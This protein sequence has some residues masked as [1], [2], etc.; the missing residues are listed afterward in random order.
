MK[1]IKRTSLL[2]MRLSPLR[3][4]LKLFALWVLL[5]FHLLV[6]AISFGQSD[7]KNIRFEY[8][9]IEHGL[10]KSIV[11]DIIRDR[12][13]FMWFATGYGLNRFDGYN[14][15]VFKN[16]PFNDSS[17]PSNDIRT[18]YEDPNGEIWIGSYERGISIY[19][20]E[21]ENFRS[22]SYSETDN[23][24]LSHNR[25]NT[26]IGHNENV[27]IGTAHGLNRFDKKS[28]SFE[29]YFHEPDNP[30]S[31][32][33]NNIQSLLIDSQGI[34]WVGTRNGLNRY[35]PQTDD[36]ERFYADGR[37]GSLP[38]STILALHEDPKGNLW[39]GTKN[40]GLCKYLPHTNSFKIHPIGPKIDTKIKLP[41]VLSIESDDEGKL[42]I[43]TW[44]SGLIRLNPHT[45]I[46]D[47]FLPGASGGIGHDQ[48]WNVYN[49]QFG[50]MWFGTHGGGVNKYVPGSLKF[51][52]YHPHSDNTNSLNDKV[53]LSIIE[54]S[55]GYVWIGTYSGGLN[56][57]DQEG[58]FKAYQAH[59]DK[60]KG[61]INNRTSLITEDHKGNLWIGSASVDGVG[62]LNYFNR[63]SNTFTHYR[64]QPYNPN[65]LS[66]DDVWTVFLDPDSILW[67][68]TGGAGLDRYD[69]RTGSFSN[70]S[71]DPMD[72]TTISDNRIHSIY[73]DSY[74][75]M[76]VCTRSGLN[77][78]D[79]ENGKF[80]RYTLDQ[81]TPN[82]ISDNYVSNIL[83]DNSNRYW[84]GTQNGLNLFNYETGEFQNIYSHHG[85]PG[86][87]IKSI[88][89]DEQGFLWISTDRG[90]AR[91]NPDEM[92]FREYS[93]QDGLQSEE[94][95]ENAAFK[96]NSGM[97]YFG[98][99]NGFNMFH[100]DSI[101][102][103]PYIPPVVI[104]ELKLFNEPVQHGAEGSPLSKS[105]SYT[106]EIRLSYRQSMITFEFVALNFTNPEKNQYA[107]K[108][109]GFDKD[110]VYTGSQR[111]AV[112]TNLNPGEYIFRVK[113]SNN[114]KLWNEE[115]TSVRLVIAPPFWKTWWFRVLLLIVIVAGL[116]LLHAARVRKI[117]LRKKV[118][119]RQVAERTSEVKNQYKLLEE[120][121]ILLMEQREEL[122]LQTE[123]LLNSNTELE[124]HRSKIKDQAEKIARM[125]AFLEKKNL[126]L[127]DEVKN[128][129]QA[130][131]M[132]KRV[133]FEEFKRIY[134]DD[135]S[136]F[137][138]LDDL[139]WS[140]GFECRKCG[141]TEFSYTNLIKYS[142][143]F[144]RRCK[145]CKN[146]E[147]P[148]VGTIFYH[149]KFP[150][151]KA[152]YILFLVSSGKN[153]TA[154]ELSKILSLRRQ[155][156]W[157]FQK[158]V[159]EIIAFSRGTKK[160]K[161]GWSH[162]IVQRNKS[163]VE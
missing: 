151:I 75:R 88:L 157:N 94:F 44:N 161:D 86:D 97:I 46:F 62:G 162:L 143:P 140:D 159:K 80:I 147:S 38:D 125:N 158:K 58:T 39:I 96:G 148:T 128:I 107:Y 56:R 36:F 5:F 16:D 60:T 68:G 99:F 52:H 115:G 50:T 64:H 61:P 108:L 149:I 98:G 154:D 106:S 11:Y 17:I 113:G 135:E 122:T 24:T 48:V 81:N 87:F 29:N 2:K 160:N 30:N 79:R 146:I 14:F 114:D 63:E 7:T 74:D 26:I 83:L 95:S 117:R 20:P 84:V 127:V 71:Y 49:D 103:N 137:K 153:Y 10:S 124:L 144:T 134:P 6:P 72:T 66:M 90:L 35:N 104:T 19:N 65:S 78:M 25:V 13:G 32:S 129:E 40:K 85:L 8:L 27:W 105:I 9:G 73:L 110:W 111:A 41:T 69:T 82:S 109:E 136:C 67:I 15:T 18:L 118:L 116:L 42:W 3:I 126:T 22:F 132:Q 23:T 121:N 133:T 102:E 139:K 53:V 33:Y 112:Y 142:L 89:E 51:K 37:S 59:P 21:E 120:R 156:A 138:F 43:G 141:S 47:L 54:D 12:K 145:K 123:K 101:K 34:L 4:V 31:L 76:W 93:S 152:F 130:R 45:G 77:L 163:T 91:F 1:L 131:I 92:S 57:M 119:E 55:K 155:T 70:Y 28:N 100:P 150:V